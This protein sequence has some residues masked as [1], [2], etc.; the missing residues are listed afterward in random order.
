MN[1][2]ALPEWQGSSPDAKVPARVRLRV[3]EAYG[4]KCWLSNRK[5][6]AGDAWDLDHKIALI[7]GGLH[8]ESNL[9]PALR[10]KHREKTAEDV[11]E[12][13]RTYRQR[14]KHLGL[15]TKGQKIASRGFQKRNQQFTEA[16]K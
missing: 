13:S 4:G 2:R 12:K 16:Q 1:A 8:C 7:N 3:F 11:D 5:I 15:W 10:D 9:A 6:M 14:A